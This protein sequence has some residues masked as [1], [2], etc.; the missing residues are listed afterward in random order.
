MPECYTCNS[1]ISLSPE[2][3]SCPPY[4]SHHEFEC[5][6]YIYWIRSTY[7]EAKK[8]ITESQRYTLFHD[9]NWCLPK[10]NSA[11][12]GETA[13]PVLH[14]E[15]VFRHPTEKSS[16]LWPMPTRAMP[17]GEHSERVFYPAREIPENSATGAPTRAR[18]WAAGALLG[19]RCRLG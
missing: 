9:L 12:E 18:T 19:V 3:R 1:P 6:S 8:K 16:E 13:P 11:G 15:E 2:V 14:Y 17:C 10:K 4:I 7:L 5:L